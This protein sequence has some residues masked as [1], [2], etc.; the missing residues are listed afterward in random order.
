V[1][2]HQGG[3]T[4]KHAQLLKLDFELPASIC[5]KFDISATDEILSA[6]REKTIESTGWRNRNKVTGLT[7]PDA[8]G[9]PIFAT[10]PPPMPQLPPLNF[11]GPDVPPEEEEEKHDAAEE[12]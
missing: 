4:N 1:A 2:G 5:E 6:E 7:K 11:G 10:K 3:Y 12:Q 8:T 9:Q